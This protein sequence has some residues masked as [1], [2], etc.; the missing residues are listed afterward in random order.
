MSLTSLSAGTFALIIALTSSGL[1]EIGGPSSHSKSSP[2]ARPSYQSPRA[3]QASTRG[4]YQQQK[5]AASVEEKAG[6]PAHEP[7]HQEQKHDDGAH[8]GYTGAGGPE[9]WARYDGC[10]A[11]D[12]GMEQS[13]VDIP[14][15]M[16]THEADIEFSYVPMSLSIVNNGH[17]IQVNAAR[18]SSIDVEGKTYKLLQF[19]F[20]ALSEHTYAGQHSDMEVHFVHKSDDGQFAVVGVF[21][22]KGEH[23]PAFGP[24]LSNLPQKAGESQYVN[25]VAINTIDLLPVE[26]E[27]YRY[28]GSFTTPPCTEG[29]KWFVMAQPLELSAEQVS[30]FTALYDNNYRPVQPI[31]NRKFKAGS[32][33]CE[34]CQARKILSS[35]SG[36]GLS[37]N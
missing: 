15:G 17:T 23:N 14:A 28:D 19:H 29:V 10:E 21:L 11:C 3:R 4:K 26:R 30:S 9:N 1:G 20:H 32:S 12:E 7:A 27:Y 18:D 5:P 36:E 34:C 37:D 24:V 6:E 33:S 16:P 22:N 8:W 31:N 13:P 35:Y 2:A 25:G